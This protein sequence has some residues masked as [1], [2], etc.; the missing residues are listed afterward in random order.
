M[1]IKS[2]AGRVLRELARNQLL[3]ELFFLAC[4]VALDW[5]LRK[6]KEKY[7]GFVQRWVEKIFSQLT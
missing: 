1:R 3:G 4:L 7:T 5:A 6:D 2:G